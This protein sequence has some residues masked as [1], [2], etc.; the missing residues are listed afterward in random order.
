MT[1]PFLRSDLVR[2]ENSSTVAYPDSRGIPTIGI[3]HTGRE[4]HLGLVWTPAEITVAFN[5]DLAIA[6]EGITLNLP[7]QSELSGLRQDCLANIAFNLGVHGLLKFDTFLGFMKSG[8]YAS[9]ALDLTHTLWYGE[10][11]ERSARICRQ[12]ETNVHQG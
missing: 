3:G 9:A 5:H 6:E 11:G 1:T 2:D 4:V 12:I 8:D 10:V 7:W